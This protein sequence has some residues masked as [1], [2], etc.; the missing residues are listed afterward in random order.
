MPL[1]VWEPE[2]FTVCH[3]ILSRIILFNMRS[4]V[5]VRALDSLITGSIPSTAI[6]TGLTARLLT[7][8]IPLMNP[9]EVAL[10]KYF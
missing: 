7:C 9:I 8:S 2:K 5:K 4:N 10:F 1:T 6:D 3:K